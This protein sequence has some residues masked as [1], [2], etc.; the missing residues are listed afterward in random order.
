MSSAFRFNLNDPNITIAEILSRFPPTFRTQFAAGIRLIASLTDQQVAQ[1]L[2][3]VTDSIVSTTPVAD[4]EIASKFSLSPQDASASLLAANVLVVTLAS[5]KVSPEQ[6]LQ[7]LRDLALFDEKQPEGPLH[8]LKS[9][10]NI[11][12]PINESIQRTALAAEGLPVLTEFE[13]IVD[14]R[15]AF[16]KEKQHITFAV[17]V[18]I[19]HIDTDSHGSEVWLQINKRQ[20]EKMVADL[21]TALDQMTEAERWSKTD[22]K[23]K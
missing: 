18:L 15:P 7:Q 17:P 8:F 1:L 4:K 2:E 23:P 21:K 20:L 13:A 3:A 5:S 6:L 9:A 14:I 22:L 12:G 19:L 16:D 11:R 10:E